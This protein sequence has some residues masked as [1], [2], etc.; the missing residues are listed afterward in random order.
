MNKIFISVTVLVLALFF[1]CTPGSKKAENND[2]AEKQETVDSLMEKAKAFF[3]LLPAVALSDENISTEEKVLLGKAL[4]FDVRLSKDNTQS[5]NTC[6]NLET[7]GVDNLPTSPGNNGELG[8]RNSPTVLNAALHSSQFWD[9]RDATIEDQAGGP[10]LNPVEM[11]IPSKQFLIDRLST[12]DEYKA[13]FAQ[14]F[15]DEADPITYMNIQNAIGAFER[16]LITPARFDDYLSGNVSALTEVEIEG[17]QTFINTGCT[18][19]H[20]GNALGGN[21]FHK[22]GLFG[23]YWDHTKSKAIDNGRF[24]VTQKESDKYV[25]KVPS[26]RNI[27]KTYPYFHDG[28]IDDL[29]ESVLIMAKLELNKD[30]SDE[31]AEEI[32]S[33]LATLTGEVPAHLKE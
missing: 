15:P 24:D 20:L 10:I 18:T 12:I 30:L 28:S 19:C 23:N 29:K 14:A 17:L 8:T 22:F 1:G 7:Y 31:E 9:G 3:G 25:F 6:H 4:Y 33:F 5:C 16:E 2:S 27:D 26:L 13:L 32:V 21:M 11:A